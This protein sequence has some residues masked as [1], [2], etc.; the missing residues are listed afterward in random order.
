[1]LETSGTV[2]LHHCLFTLFKGLENNISSFEN[3]LTLLYLRSY[4]K[5]NAGLT[6]TED[7]LFYNA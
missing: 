7:S 5:C 2:A 3:K 6:N 1:M 4:T